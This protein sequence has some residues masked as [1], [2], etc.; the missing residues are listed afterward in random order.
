MLSKLRMEDCTPVN[1]PMVT[2]CK[3]RKNDEA[4]EANQT[5]YRSMIGILLYVTT[6]R[7]DIMQAIGV[8]AR[9]QASPKETRVQAVKK[10]FKY[11]KG[12]LDFCL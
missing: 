12:T 5:L 9:F 8:V 10:I 3:L 7:L 6:L 1:T 11:I 4:P 2:S